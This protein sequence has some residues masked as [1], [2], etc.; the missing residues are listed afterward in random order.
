VLQPFQSASFSFPSTCA[1]LQGVLFPFQSE[2]VRWF[3]PA[4]P[5]FVRFV[6]ISVRSNLLSLCNLLAGHTDPLEARI[7]PSA[8]SFGVSSRQLPSRLFWPAL[9]E[10]QLGHTSH[11][12]TSASCSFQP[13]LLSRHSASCGLQSTLL[14]FSSA[15]HLFQSALRLFA[16]LRVY[17]NS[18]FVHVH[19]FAICINPFRAHVGCS[20]YLPFCFAFL[21]ICFLPHLM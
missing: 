7:C 1:S 4:M 17:F 9:H 10:F 5:L 16:W 8:L 15:L 18:Y 2:S 14:S 6:R 21:S 3:V 19:P 13:F 11:P 12:F 20:S